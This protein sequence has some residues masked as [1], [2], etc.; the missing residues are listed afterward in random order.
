MSFCFFVRMWKLNFSIDS[1]GSDQC[2]V[3]T[4]DSVGGHD[5]FDIA[6]GGEPVELG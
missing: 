5:D 1:T 3:E 4:V 2:W 6:S